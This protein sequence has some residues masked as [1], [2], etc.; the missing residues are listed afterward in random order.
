MVEIGS[1]EN[2]TKALEL[3]NSKVKNGEQLSD[4]ELQLLYANLPILVEMRDGKKPLAEVENK[5]KAEYKNANKARIT[6]VDE[7]IANRGNQKTIKKGGMGLETE[8][9]GLIYGTLV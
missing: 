9:I 2:Q 3:Y 6:F 8:D 7:L 5:D 4:S 1:D